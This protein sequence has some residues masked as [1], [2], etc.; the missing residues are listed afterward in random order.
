MIFSPLVVVNEFLSDESSRK[1]AISLNSQ[2][3]QG[4]G[5]NSKHLRINNRL[6]ALS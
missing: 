4:P 5:D 2:N 1:Q 6:N 3:G